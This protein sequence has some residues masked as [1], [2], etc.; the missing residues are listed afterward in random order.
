[1]KPQ[2]N[3]PLLKKIEHDIIQN[4]KC[5]TIILYGS[6]A[7]GEATSTSDYDILAIRENGDLERDCRLFENFY[8]DIF[9]Y[10]EEAI[11]NP[12]TSLIRIK[13]GIV[14]RQKDSMG[15]DLLVKIKSIFNA[16]PPATPTW[17]KHEINTW[18]MKMLD[19]AKQD[20]IE[21]NFRRHWL[22]HDLLECYFKL[23]DKWYLGPKES[24]QYLKKSD[25]QTYVAFNKA[26]QSDASFDE[27]E[28]L[29]S[30]VKRQRRRCQVSS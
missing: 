24:F 13:D 6:R 14:L 15:D 10:S 4:Y 8:L 27:I 22:L 26:L 19:R 18:V 28:K 30:C 16:G 17:E 1:M 9:V 5:H 23:R 12:D 11:R 29:I 3:D 7:R 21:G 25:M 20:D 2:N